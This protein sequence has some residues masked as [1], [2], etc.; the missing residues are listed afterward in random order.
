MNTIKENFIAIAVVVG[1]AS[2]FIAGAG[3]YIINSF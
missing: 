1:F 3:S 2:I